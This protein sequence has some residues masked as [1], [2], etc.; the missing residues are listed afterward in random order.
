MAG[1]YTI[2]G[3]SYRLRYRYKGQNFTKTIKL[4]KGQKIDIE[5]QKFVEEVEN[6]EIINS[7]I[8]FIDFAQKWINDYARVNLRERTV[9]GYLDYINLRLAPYFQNKYIKD[10]E[11][12]DVQKFLNSLTNEL[13]TATI[14]KYKNCLS[15]MF[16]YAVR[17]NFL[18]Y[19]P[20]NG[21]IVPKGKKSNTQPSF[22]DKNEAQQLLDCLKEEPLKYQVIVRLALQCGL[23]RSEI[24]ALT[25]KAIDFSNNTISI[26]QA[27]STLKG[28]TVI[29]E[30]KNKS[31]I[32]TIYAN[33]DL[34]E[35]IKTLPN[36]HNLILGYMHN[37]TV[38]KWFSKFLKKHNLKHIRFHDLRHTHATLLIANNVDMKTVSHRLG[39]S[40]ISTTMNI[41]THP[42]AENDL[43]ASKII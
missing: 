38:T 29:S 24:L 36:T 16:K 15:C 32:R 8:G 23:R 7:K 30:T 19:N 22:L 14:R 25:W 39:H 35:L 17:W 34:I 42:L 31:S 26:F 33:P 9:N 41:Y 5:L 3:D 12:Y 37:D 21:V 2:R 10:I 40:N 6:K 1:S 13:S 4:N 27:T 18:K 11:L 20:C 28:G 43:I